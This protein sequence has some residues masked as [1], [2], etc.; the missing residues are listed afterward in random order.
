MKETDAVT[1]DPNDDAPI[2][3]VVDGGKDETKPKTDIKKGAD[4]LTN[5]QRAFC[6]AMLAGAGSQSDAYR[7]AYDVT[8]MS[9][10]AIHTEAS[11]MMRHPAIAQRLES[12]F[13]AQDEAALLS[14]Q[15]LRGY[16][17]KSLYD[18]S[19]A[20]DSD[21]NKLKALH[22]LGQTE[23]CGVF[24]T[25]TL[26]LTETLT[27]AEVEQELADKLKDAFKSRA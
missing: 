17:E 9:D 5:K 13:K 14:G 12:G 20:A 7:R 24:V 8:S 25:R 6:K 18:L 1:D 22:L 16:V 2:L 15:S 27:P 21:A 26:D 10:A 3:T 19:K 4:N 23:K 11:K